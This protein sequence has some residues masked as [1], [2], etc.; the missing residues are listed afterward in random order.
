M[1]DVRLYGSNT[2]AAIANFDVSGETVDHRIIEALAHIKA[3]CAIANS[4]ADVGRLDREIAAAIVGA[5]EEVAT[6]KHRD[7][8]PVD[9]FQTGSGTSTN[10]NVNEVLASIA[11]SVSGLAVHPNDHV[12]MSQSTNDTFPTAIRVAVS[13]AIRD[14][15]LPA[16]GQ[17]ADALADKAVEFGDVVKPGR[18]HLMDATPVMLGDEFGGYAA[19]IRESIERIASAQTR[20]VRLPLGGTATG[21]GLNTPPG[22]AAMVRELL[23]ER[24]GVRWQ[25][26]LHHFAVQGGQDALVE[27]SAQLRGAALAMFKIANDIRLMASGPRTGLGELTLTELQ[28]GS[29]IMPGKTNPVICEVVIQVCAQVVGNDTA[30]A[31]AGSR[32]E[33]ELN[34]YLPV[35]ARNLLESVDLLAGSC[36]SL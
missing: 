4:H 10:M 28:P 15:L 30:I 33:L 11:S 27:A 32:G 17:L 13:L 34:V 9:V 6:G 36:T 29:S 8:F 22:H 21:N 2:Q 35:M 12:N 18:T 3:C 5:A 20:L 25:P 19:Q 7:Q 31:F 26:P 16:L 23:T 1:N 24:T 14:Q